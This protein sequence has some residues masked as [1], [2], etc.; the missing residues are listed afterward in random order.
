MILHE[1]ILTT[2][3]LD[4]TLPHGSAANKHDID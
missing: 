1:L 2:S 3:M 4:M